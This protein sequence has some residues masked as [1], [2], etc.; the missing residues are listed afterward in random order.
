[1]KYEN[2]IAAIEK[3]KKKQEDM[4]EG[5]VRVQPTSL[6]ERLSANSNDLKFL[7]Y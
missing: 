4:L 3:K 7:N 1:L 6:M 5:S 2:Q